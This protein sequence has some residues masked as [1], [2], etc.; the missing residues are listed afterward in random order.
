MTLHDSNPGHCLYKNLGLFL[1]DYNGVCKE[2]N[3]YV[4]LE[5][6]GFNH[7]LEWMH[8]CLMI[9]VGVYMVDYITADILDLYSHRGR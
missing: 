8:G 5:L 3:S 6:H 4:L 9:N 1:K 2:H 7:Y